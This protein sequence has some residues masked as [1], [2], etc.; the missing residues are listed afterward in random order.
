[1][2]QTREIE[3]EAALEAILGGA[4][5]LDVRE[6]EELRAQAFA[7]PNSLHI[8]LGQI[9]D[10]SG[11]AALPPDRTLVVACLGGWRSANA[12]ATL[13]R[14]GFDAMNLAGGWL[15]W[16]GA[17][18]PAWEGE[19]PGACACGCNDDAAG[20]EDG[21]CGCSAGVPIERREEV[22][23]TTADCGCSPADA[24]CC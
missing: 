10:G 9:L 17:G 24:T 2:T 11:I 7:V 20:A 16:V 21:A 12:T 23:M 18:L 6:P 4:V 19:A 5:L 8:P 13:E 1:M 15:A 22:P 14:A 3:P